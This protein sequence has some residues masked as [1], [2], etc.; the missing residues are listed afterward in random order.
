MRPKEINKQV[1]LQIIKAAMLC[2]SKNGYKKTSIN[3]IAVEAKVSKALVFHYFN[4]KKALYLFIYEYCTEIIQDEINTKINSSETD[5][6][7]KIIMIQNIKLDI[8]TRYPGVF[9]FLNSFNSEDDKEI[10]Q[11]IL[12]AKQKNAIQPFYSAF[13]NID[14]SKFKEGFPKNLIIK[15]VLWSL[16]GLI[17]ELTA[18]EG[19]DLQSIKKEFDAYMSFLK[20]V[21]YKEEK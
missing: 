16:N 14:Y 15:N 10:E 8:M 9:K 2:F 21:F 17:S 3:D 5:F 11:K 19:Y 18:K 20:E 13:T 6:F 12:A 1:K 7:K 4:N